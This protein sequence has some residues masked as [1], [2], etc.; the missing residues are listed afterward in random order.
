MDISHFW[1][2]DLSVSSTGDLLPVDGYEKGQQR[3]L[4]RLFTAPGTYIW[5]LEYGA[6]VQR[7]IGAPVDEGILRGI[8]RSQIMLEAAVAPEPVPQIAAVDLPPG[9]LFFRIIYTDADTGFPVPL[10]F[11]VSE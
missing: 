2:G 3:I 6:G 11:D 1:G 10:Q 5:H 7:Y 4:R 9:S 8:V